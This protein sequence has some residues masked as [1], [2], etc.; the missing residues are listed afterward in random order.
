MVDELVEVL[1][2]VNGSLF[3][4]GLCLPTTCSA[5]EVELA[6]NTSELSESFAKLLLKLICLLVLYPILHI[7][8][9]VG[10]QCSTAEQSQQW[11]PLDGYQK[12]AM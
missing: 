11:G 9:K 10:P 8:L 6:L 1:Y 12:M 7:P 2:L 3:Q 5:G 4:L